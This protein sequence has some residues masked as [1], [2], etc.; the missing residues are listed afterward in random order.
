MKNS[1]PN[2]MEDAM[3]EKKKFWAQPTLVM[4]LFKKS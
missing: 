2:K 1:K 4:T 3:E